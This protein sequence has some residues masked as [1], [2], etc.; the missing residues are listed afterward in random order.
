MIG[1][2]LFPPKHLPRVRNDV[3]ATPTGALTDGRKQNPSLDRIVYFSSVRLSS[4]DV[5]PAKLP[6]PE[7]EF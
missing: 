3:D 1:F 4:V 7:L 5:P 2:S 6:L